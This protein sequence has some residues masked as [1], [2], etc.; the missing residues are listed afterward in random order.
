VTAYGAL[1]G[2]ILAGIGILYVTAMKFHRSYVQDEQTRKGRM[3]DLTRDNQDITAFCETHGVDL[4][5]LFGSS[6]TG[7]FHPESDVDVALQFKKGIKP[8]RLHLIHE[9][10]MLIEPRSIDLVV[11]T[12]DTP[13]LLLYEIFM[14]GKPLYEASERLFEKGKIRAWHLYLD[15]APL[16]KREK[17]YVRQ[18]VKE[19]TDVA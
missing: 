11:L 10:E 18:L 2:R 4:F 13:P 15:T 19:M 5:I 9:L 3:T 8:S 7:K 6:I 14:R 1:L 17:E 16:R 12:L